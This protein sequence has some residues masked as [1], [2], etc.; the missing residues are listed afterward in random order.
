MFVLDT[1]TFTHLLRGRPQ[2]VER[3]ARFATEVVLTEVTR[4][5]QLQGRFD[6]VFK[7]EDAAALIRAGQRLAETETDLTRLPLLLLDEAAA[8][9]FERLIGTRGLRRL[10][11]GD[12]LIASVSL[13]R[14]ATLV[15][16][17]LKDF[18]KVPGL[19]IENWA[20]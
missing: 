1:D 7:A 9:V 17:N 6:A 13:A 16:R 8:A 14:R 4:I 20:D 12:L 15:T 10:G 3:V 19:R 5:E 18:G 2:V 11:R